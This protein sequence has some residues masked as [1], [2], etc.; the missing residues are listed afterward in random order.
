MMAD[1][2]QIHAAM[3]PGS[4]FGDPFST[5]VEINIRQHALESACFVV[6]AT[7]WLTP[8]QQAQI[9]KDTGGELG[10]ISGGCFTAIVT[11]DGMLIGEPI[12]GG[13]A[14]VVAD[15]DFS[16]IDRRKVLMD[17]RGHYARPEL[18]SLLID[19]T[20]TAH[21]HER[22]A[23]RYSD[24]EQGPR[25]VELDGRGRLK[26]AAEERVAQRPLAHFLRD[27]PPP[28]KGAI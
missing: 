5:K 4:M 25:E 6:C 27:S 16:L 14:E 7:A 24:A 9:V 11:P 3:Y 15:L 23:C 12:R 21:V 13:E 19:R 8:D 1:G 26:M 22:H 18:L 17:S 28:S 20:P 2:E 10:P